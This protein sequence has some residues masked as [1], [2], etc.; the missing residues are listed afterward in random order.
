MR[1]EKLPGHDANNSLADTVQPVPQGQ[2]ELF[3]V[4][5]GARNAGHVH[6]LLQG[7]DVL[8]DQR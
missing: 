5:K 4:E 3:L 6:G 8:Q 1:T 7:Q 2:K